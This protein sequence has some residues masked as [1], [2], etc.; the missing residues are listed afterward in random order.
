MIEESKELKIINNK[1]YIIIITISIIIILIS[2]ISVIIMLIRHNNIIKNYE[3][4]IKRI[5]IFEELKKREKEKE[6]Q[7][8]LQKIEEQNK[9]LKLI[10]IAQK[11]INGFKYNKSA[12]KEIDKIYDLD[13][14]YVY[15]TFDD[16]PSRITKEVL[17]ILKEENIPATF[18]IV[19]AY[20]EGNED[21][22]RRIYNEGHTIGNHSF[23]H[24]YNKIY[25]SSEET[26]K[27]YN[28]TEKE[29]KNLRK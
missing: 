17:D 25:K 11:E 27:E 23:S 28:Q 8:R 14:K 18:F 2:L 29:L 20:I 15:L 4:K 19:G 26:L 1:R 13:I 12:Q 24:K 3:D 10:S 22:I 16:G 21:I 7:K 5:E 9:N 6:K